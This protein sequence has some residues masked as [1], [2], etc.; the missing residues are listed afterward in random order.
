MG[1]FRFKSTAAKKG[2]MKA[3]WPVAFISKLTHACYAYISLGPV[4]AKYNSV[5]PKDNELHL[6]YYKALKQH[7]WMSHKTKDP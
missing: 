3:Y 2:L 4:K 1:L 6:L 5:E 7:D